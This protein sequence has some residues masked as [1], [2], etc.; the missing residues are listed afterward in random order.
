MEGS[1]VVSNCSAV[2]LGHKV[3]SNPHQDDLDSVLGAFQRQFNMFLSRFRRVPP[4]VKNRLFQAY[5]TSFYG[6]QLCNLSKV[7]KLKVAYRK[8]VRR[9]LDVPYRTHCAIL[10]SLTDSLCVEH[11]FIK[12]FATFAAS[13]LQH[14]FPIVQYILRN[15]LVQK[16]SIFA[17]NCT[18]CSLDFGQNEH[19]DALSSHV[20]AQCYTLCRTRELNAVAG[21]IQDLLS[22]RFGILHCG[23]TIQEINSLIYVL[24]TN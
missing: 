15:S 22:C 11:M 7:Q 10:P 6:L 3:F 1:N 5:C 17:V 14:D 4:M 2:H 20:K 23:L 21:A 13:G 12:R 19:F 24:C 8:N 9:L 18:F 16:T